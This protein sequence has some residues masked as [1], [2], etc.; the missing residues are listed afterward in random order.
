MS[1]VNDKAKDPRRKTLYF[2]GETAQL[3]KERALEEHR[4]ESNYL[5]HLIIQDHRAKQMSA[6]SFTPAAH[7]QKQ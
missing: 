3:L 2:N 1:I 4:S 7:R 5:Q 6:P